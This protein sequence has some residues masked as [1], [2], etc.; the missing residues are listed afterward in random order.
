MLTRVRKVKYLKEYKLLIS[1]T[2]G[3][4]KVFDMMR[5]IEKGGVFTPLRDIEYFKRVSVN[6]ESRTIEWPNGVDICP[7]TLYKD[8]TELKSA[9][10]KASA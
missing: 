5:C 1:F 7:D 4:E 6:P 8:G 10:K 2:D 9:K 3:S